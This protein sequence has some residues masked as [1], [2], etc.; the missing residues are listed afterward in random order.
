MSALSTS[1]LSASRSRPGRVLAATDSEPPRATSERPRRERR[2]EVTDQRLN[3]RPTS[4]RW[5]G[6]ASTRLGDELV[7]LPG[8]SVDLLQTRLGLDDHRGILVQR[9]LVEPQLDGGQPA[10][11]LM[12][13]TP[14]VSR[15]RSSRSAISALASPSADDTRSSSLM[16][17]LRQC[18]ELA[19]AHR[20]GPIG[21][22]G[23]QVGQAPG[24]HRGHNR[25]AATEAAIT[26][27]TMP[28]AN[29]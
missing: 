16:P 7:E 14:T 24:R 15:S 27:A 20:R 10:A 5:D 1:T 19:P 2:G 11:Q 26:I 29:N 28:T 23:E 18:A 6:A 13:H 25:S 21:E 4:T 3:G 9:Q 22:I 12:G 17:Y 8:E